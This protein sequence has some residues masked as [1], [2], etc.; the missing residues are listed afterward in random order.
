[1]NRS[2]FEGKV[3]IV[4]GGSMGIGRS[5]VVQ[6]VEEGAHVVTCARRKPKLDELD[7]AVKDLSGS[8]T[9]YEL[10]VG[11]TEAFARLINETAQ[12]VRSAGCTGE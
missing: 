4:T 12:Q 1:M 5:T 11:D 6:L 3:A 9:G 7:E 2:R 8:F 10:D